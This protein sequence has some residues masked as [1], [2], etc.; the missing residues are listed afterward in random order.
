MHSIRIAVENS[1][2]DGRPQLTVTSANVDESAPF[3][4]EAA[5]QI[6]RAFNDVMQFEH[7]VADPSQRHD[8]QTLATVESR[9]RREILKGK[10]GVA[11]DDECRREGYNKEVWIKGLPS[12]L[13][14]PWE[15]LRSWNQ[16]LFDMNDVA[17]ARSIPAEGPSLPL[18]SQ[19]DE[20]GEGGLR[21]LFAPAEPAGLGVV[22]WREALDELDQRLWFYREL[23]LARWEVLGEAAAPDTL[24][25]LRRQISDRQY[26]VV[27]LLAHGRVA[28][29]PQVA[30]VGRDGEPRWTSVHDLVPTLTRGGKPPRMVV[31]GCCHLS[32]VV[33]YG[34]VAR[35]LIESGV[36]AVLSMQSTVSTRGAA[37]VAAT[38]LRSILRGHSLGRAVLECRRAL[39]GHESVL[40]TLWLNPHWKQHEPLV[41]IRRL[42]SRDLVSQARDARGRGDVEARA[43]QML[44]KLCYVEDVDGFGDSGE[45]QLKRTY[46]R[47]IVNMVLPRIRRYLDQSVEEVA[48]LIC[49]LEDRCPDFVRDNDELKGA[50]KRV[51]AEMLSAVRE[52]AA[53]ESEHRWQEAV[54]VCDRAISRQTPSFHVERIC[55]DSQTR[56][57]AHRHYCQANALLADA[58]QEQDAGRW[59]TATQLKRSALAHFNYATREA[60]REFRWI[61]PR[62]EQLQAEVAAEQ[63]VND[64]RDAMLGFHWETAASKM[65]E[66]AKLRPEG[67]PGDRQDEGL[68]KY[69]QDIEL[70]VASAHDLATG[71]RWDEALESIRD[72]TPESLVPRTNGRQDDESRRWRNEL[73]T[74]WS[75]HLNLDQVRGIWRRASQAYHHLHTLAGGAAVDAAGAP[76]NV[77]A[78]LHVSP[79][80]AA[81]IESARR[82]M[83]REMPSDLPGW[84]ADQ[85]KLDAPCFFALEADWPAARKALFRLCAQGH[86]V[87]P[88]YHRLAVMAM[89]RGLEGQKPGVDPQAAAQAWCECLQAWAEVLAS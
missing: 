6:C 21:V 83:R 71:G 16:N 3:D 64:A 75:R 20:V 89:A 46:V 78:V 11:L 40:P 65:R 5:D 33:E 51:N 50:K 73:L 55:R 87:A 58:R 12:H 81:A 62:I 32:R 42:S 39:S 37:V 59:V 69:C 74:S 15:L 53:A 47:Q 35:Q 57:R 61:A 76:A 27:Y 70:Q 28:G 43:E 25:R 17:V 38:L 18:V 10:T 30:L 19:S 34:G 13:N 63:L 79:V 8:H 48:Q 26:D 49:W 56:L 9:F 52:V 23:G 4:V 14:L 22:H 68:I 88:A 2:I 82:G 60:D 66:A 1:P 85:L 45:I 24:A 86:D 36:P 72:I 77:R 67:F 31:L 54:S 44:A 84:L 7:G 29:E 80:D 41:R